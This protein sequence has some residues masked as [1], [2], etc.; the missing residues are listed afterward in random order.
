MM[1]RL[2]WQLNTFMRFSMPKMKL[3]SEKSPF[4]SLLLAPIA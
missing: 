3:T 2:E 4:L 1:Q